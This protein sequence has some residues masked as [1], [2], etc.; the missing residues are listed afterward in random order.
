M[1]RKL[2]GDKILLW[3]VCG[4]LLFGSAALTFF[5]AARMSEREN[6]ILA[7]LPTPSAANMA[8][9]SYTAGLDTY[10]TE[11]F[12][13]R[14][15][16]R[17]ARAA[18][19]IG[20]G[21]QEVGGVLLCT[22]GSLCKRITP[23]GRAYQKNLAAL[24]DMQHAYG[25]RLT[26][27]VAPRRIDARAAVLPPL[28]DADENAAV[29]DTLAG[30]LPHAVTFPALTADAHWYRTD[31][32]WTTLGAYEAYLQLGGV[33]GYTPYAETD[34]R[35][36]TVSKNFLGTSDAAA[37]LPRIS[38]DSIQ[39]YRY[40]GDGAYTVKKDGKA[41]PFAGVYDM[42]KLQTRD[43][44]A[45]FFGGNCGFLEITYSE[46]RPTLL[47][48]KDSFANALLPFLA[49]HY[50]VIALDPRYC[51]D[52]IEAYARSADRI[53]CLMGMQTLCT[54]VIFKSV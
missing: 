15:P 9:G 21:R 8:D 52:G 39:L 33:L 46:N 20:L 3:T 30:S 53:L 41:T 4:A 23:N 12:P 37:G 31:H 36:E 42:E 34:F 49:R 43:Q 2:V 14:V 7:E 45:V 16:L 35:A 22:D 27:A 18:L 5:P 11:R 47:L 48:I 44:Y 26:V 17:A 19:E 10:A 32:H 6:R 24:Q 40:E 51:A 29:W 50:R 28:Y 25:D 1:K 54:T 13:F 38:P